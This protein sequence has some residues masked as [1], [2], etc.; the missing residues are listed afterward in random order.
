MGM[1]FGIEKFAKLV[2]EKGKIVTSVGIELP[3]GKVIKSVKKG[4]I[5]KYLIISR[6]QYLDSV[7]LDTQ[8]HLLVQ[9]SVSCGL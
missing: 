8:Q 4:E 7:P 1:E 6:S 2:I 5:Y 3:D 9:E